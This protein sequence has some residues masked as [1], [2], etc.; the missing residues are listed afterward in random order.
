MEVKKLRIAFII[1]SL[2]KN[3]ERLISDIKQHFF[4]FNTTLLETK[5]ANHAIEL[6]TTASQENDVIIA[7]GGDGTLNEVINGSL[8][9]LHSNLKIGLLSYGTANDFAKSFDSS[10]SVSELLNKIKLNS[11]Q[12]IDL[13]LATFIDH[14]GNQSSRYFNNIS[15]IGLGGDVVM[16]VNKS[17]KILGPKI[18]FSTKILQSFLTYKRQEV[19]ATSSNGFS[20]EGKILSLV[21]AN[22][23]FFGN[24]LCIAPN[25]SLTNSLLEI[26][27]M[28]EVS[29]MD[30][31]LNIGKIR[32]GE[33]I[34]HKGIQYVQLENLEVT[35]L[36]NPMPL[37]IDGEFVGYTPVQ[38]KVL[39]KHIKLIA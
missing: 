24:G 26:V 7:V 5:F 4:E 11:F 25:A 3:K 34:K 27:L 1:K 21:V 9:S 38:F 13:G 16:K 20:Y 29:L 6:A 23:R 12:E 19:E 35:A 22:G 17:K 14:K 10:K 2:I 37:D 36:E 8:K 32:K 39:P 31:V 15:D 30:Y 18:T 33:I 28:G